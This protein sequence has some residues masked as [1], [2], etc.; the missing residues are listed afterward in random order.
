MGKLNT[1]PGT[2]GCIQP[3]LRLLVR[4][5]GKVVLA[6]MW[7]FSATACVSLGVLTV[8]SS[9]N[10]VYSKLNLICL[11]MTKS[12]QAFPNIHR[13]KE[14]CWLST[15]CS[16]AVDYGILF[17]MAIE[18][19]DKC[20][21]L[22]MAARGRCGPHFNK[23]WAPSTLHCMRGSSVTRVQMVYKCSLKP[24]LISAKQ[25]DEKSLQCCTMSLQCCNEEAEFRSKYGL[26]YLPDTSR[27]FSAWQG[28]E[29]SS[30]VKHCAC[31]IS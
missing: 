18:Q 15:F 5:S 31:L 4:H 24:Y 28:W 21:K 2:L 13:W 29:G 27:L 7:A 1:R 10:T 26:S 8:Y 25:G 14:N 12:S 20:G 9:V 30:L 6:F 19:Q 23:V 11:S 3:T 16:P 22:S 17:G